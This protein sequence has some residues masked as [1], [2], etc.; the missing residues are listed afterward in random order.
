MF[1]FVATVILSACVSVYHLLAHEGQKIGSSGTGVKDG[2]QPPCGSQDSNSDSLEDPD[3]VL[4]TAEPPL[5]PTKNKNLRKREREAREMAQR[6]REPAVLA[7]KPKEE[8]SQYQN[9]FVRGL[10]LVLLVA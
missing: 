8:N 10:R 2:G 1:Y 6:F 7:G 9:G 3:L 5:Q 4:L